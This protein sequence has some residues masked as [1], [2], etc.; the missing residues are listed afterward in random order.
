MNTPDL[1]NA[2]LKYVSRENY[3]PV[4]PRVIIKK[5]GIT[6]DQ[7]RDFKRALKK[8]VKKGRVS[9][10]KNHLVMPVKNKRE[11]GIVGKFRRNRGGFGF[12]RPDGTS[13][14]AGR[15]EDIFIPAD[16]T[17]DAAN[18]DVVRVR[19][20]KR[21]S[22]NGEKRLAGEV[23]DVVERATHQ[24][25]GRY[26]EENERAFVHVDGG[27]FNLPIFVG[28]P[29]AK[30][31]QPDDKVVLE[32]VRFPTGNRT[33]EGVITDILGK[34][35]DPGVDTKSVIVAHGLPREFSEEV[36]ENAREQA[37]E[38]DESIA[39]GR[40]D[41][42]NLAVITID[43]FD[44][45]D[46]DDA[47]SL[48]RLE[49]GHWR[50]G[51]HIADVSHFVQ[52]GSPLDKEARDRAT[53]VY[54]PDMVI[55]MIPEII[56]NNLASLQ[57]DK[58]RYTKTAFIEFTEDGVR[59]ATD[60]CSAAIKSKRRFT[61]EEIDEYLED[62]EPWRQKLSPEV[63]QLVADMHQVA[64]IQRHR[65]MTRGAI[66]LTLPEIK[67]KIDSDGR[68][69][70]AEKTE[71]TESHQVIEEFMLA[72]NEAVAERF[73]D[74]ELLFLRRVH[75]SPD[76]RKLM[77]LTDFVRELGIPCESLES[78]FEIKRIIAEVADT[79]CEAAVNL[80]VLRSMQKA[81]YSPQ[82]TGHYALASQHYCHFTSPIRRYPDLTIHRLMDAVFRGI[83]KS[84]GFEPLAALGDHCSE[85][86]QRAE[87]AERELTKMKLL[88][89]LSDRIGEEMEA[90]VTGVETYGLFAQGI[91][92]PAEGLIHVSNLG[93]DHFTYDSD[94]RSLVGFREGNEFR[95]GDKLLVRIEEIDMDNLELDLRVV[96]KLSSIERPDPP[97]KPKSAKKDHRPSG[98][99]G[100]GAKGKAKAKGRK[101]R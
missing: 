69:T 100:G 92:L 10:G 90:I 37:E 75:E 28:D 76:P 29:G 67:L 78:R 88:A 48:E 36:L 87:T 43:P 93:D 6:E 82:E 22:R 97:K 95:I 42:T 84:P 30:N 50:L 40:V 64:M 9:Y 38:F 80:S 83:A 34:R 99:R 23:I 96:E 13:A 33:G 12:V 46:F 44:A 27:E 47:I 66:E 18:D 70:G 94:T 62:P 15:A 41:L 1:E 24:F 17:G 58:V 49:N 4:K 55:P 21:G 81:V 79:S 65:R 57:P 101:R 71:N 56:S 68:V 60:F 86:E 5:L 25:V 19:M 14:S 73:F 52:P 77:Q 98:K 7:K 16:K 63:F 45:R 26:F 11:S 61:Y 89:F 72:A 20:I 31:A 91:E 35:G 85:R 54:L 39:D 74:L 8:L 3:H 2:I 32:M 59:V 53:S 51:V